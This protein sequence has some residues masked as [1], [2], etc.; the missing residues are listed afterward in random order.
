MWVRW[1]KGESLNA[2]TRLSGTSHSTISGVLAKTDVWRIAESIGIDTYSVVKLTTRG[3]V[4]AKGTM[5]GRQC[6]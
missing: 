3:Q 1:Q 6:F 5:Y 2:I 4:D